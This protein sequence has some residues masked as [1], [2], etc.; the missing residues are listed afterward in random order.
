MYEFSSGLGHHLVPAHR[1]GDVLERVRDEGLQGDVVEGTRALGILQAASWNWD[2]EV[3]RSHTPLGRAPNEIF[4]GEKLAHPV[5]LGHALRRVLGVGLIACTM[6]MLCELNKTHDQ[7]HLF[8]TQ[9]GMAHY[10]DPVPLSKQEKKAEQ[11]VSSQLVRRFDSAGMALYSAP[12][13]LWSTIR[14]GVT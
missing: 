12:D 11:R 1:K 14:W 10:S 6:L 9:P 13:H 2:T 5:F 7:D 8:G 3:H 4:R